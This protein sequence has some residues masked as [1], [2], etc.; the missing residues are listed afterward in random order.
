MQMCFYS[1]AIT[2]YGNIPNILS[3]L[4]SSMYHGN[5]EILTGIQNRFQCVWTLLRYAIQHNS[6][7]KDKIFVWFIMVSFCSHSVREALISTLVILWLCL[8][9][10]SVVLDILIILSGISNFVATLSI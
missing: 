6:L 7:A 5:C 3:T 1:C 10:F 2:S 8:V 4:P 9:I